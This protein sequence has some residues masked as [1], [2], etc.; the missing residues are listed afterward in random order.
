MPVTRTELKRRV[1]RADHALSCCEKSRS[2]LG[3]NVITSLAGIRDALDQ[4][5]RGHVLALVPAPSVGVGLA[6]RV[7]TIA[8]TAA[9]QVVGAAGVVLASAALVATLA[10]SLAALEMLTLVA[11]T[12]GEVLSQTSRDCAECIDRRTLSQ[13]HT[14]E[15]QHNIN[16]LRRL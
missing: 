4:P 3:Q 9:G 11:T 16:I 7:I 12:V 1:I 6:I 13:A 14:R 10:R 8:E 2:I 5:P 15:R